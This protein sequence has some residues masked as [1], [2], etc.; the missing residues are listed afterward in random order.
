MWATF[1]HSLRRADPFRLSGLDFRWSAGQ[2]RGRRWSKAES[3]P[4][5]AQQK[6]CPPWRGL[7]VQ[8][9][10]PAT[11]GFTLTELLFV[12]FLMAMIVSIAAPRLSSLYASARIGS[13][14][15]YILDQFAS[16]GRMALRQGRAYIVSPSGASRAA[17]GL[18]SEN[19]DIGRLARNAEP[20]D[21]DLPTGWTIEFDRPLVVSASGV[22]LGSEVTLRY[23]GGVEARLT[24]EP[25]YCRVM[26]HA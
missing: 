23:R 18:S 12:L 21:I 15:A 4:A 1:L 16:L 9:A 7:A 19:Q 6:P 8:A 22:C 10:S 11:R 20:H 5:T 25:P 14:R 26:T 3:A 2:S 17:P 24:L 13:E